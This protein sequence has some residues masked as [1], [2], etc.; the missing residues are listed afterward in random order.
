MGYAEI[1]SVKRAFRHPGRHQSER[2]AEIKSEWV[3]DIIG[4]RNKATGLVW[5]DPQESDDMSYDYVASQ[6][7][8]GGMFTGYRYATAQELETLWTDAGLLPAPFNEPCGSDTSHTLSGT[9][10]CAIWQTPIAATGRESG[11]AP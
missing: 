9:H 1:K 6:F 7:S 3:A 2:P 8:K 10:P 4:I 5:L 11:D